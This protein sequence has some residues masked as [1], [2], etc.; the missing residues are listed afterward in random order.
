VPVPEIAAGS[1]RRMVAV[2]A[3]A[4]L[5]APIVACGGEPGTTAPRID[6]EG[7]SSPVTNGDLSLADSRCSSAQRRQ[8]RIRREV[9]GDQV[10]L[11]DRARLL[12]DLA[13]ERVRLARALDAIEPP[14]RQRA[15]T[16]ELVRAATAR[17]A[18]STRAGR[19]WERGAP[20]RLRFVE[21]ARTIG[22]VDCAERLSA[23]QR[24][25]IARMLDRA[26]T[27]ANAR[28]RCAE[29]GARYL[30]QEYGG[31]VGACAASNSPPVRAEQIVILELQGMDQIF[32]VAQIEARGGEAPGR[33]RARVTREDGA[34]RV[35]KLD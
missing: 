18:A 13:P 29:F 23:D 6:S 21:V 12:V 14:G 16:R 24:A 2:A 35:D 4:L 9:G 5:A 1:L 30:E 17:G 28:R 33:Y 25:V 22:L 31:G 19:L 27:S 32:A 26:L 10:T 11:D 7:R 3:G 20:E 34:Y 15:K 8:E